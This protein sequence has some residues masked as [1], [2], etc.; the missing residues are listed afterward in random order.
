[1]GTSMRKAV[2][3][4]GVMEG[5]KRW[6][7]KARKNVALRNPNWPAR[8]SLDAS[9]ETSLDTS[10]SF[11]TLDASFSAE[12]YTSVEVRDIGDIEREE[13]H[14]DQHPKVGSFHGFELT[15]KY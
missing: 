10:P 11:N 13:A 9:L 4:E 3:T 8:P 7:A 1:M 12:Y 2:F 14:I 5:L 6:K 15:D